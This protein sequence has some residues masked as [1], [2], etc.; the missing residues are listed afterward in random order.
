MEV[1]LAIV[2]NILVMVVTFF[3][4]KRLPYLVTKKPPK[5]LIPVLLILVICV[6]SSLWK[7]QTEELMAW[8]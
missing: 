5:W 2:G 6:I 1:F 4:L 8:I 3:T 7:S